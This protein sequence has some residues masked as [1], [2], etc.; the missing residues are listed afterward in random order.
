MPPDDT[1]GLVPVTEVTVP[2]G[3]DEFIVWF[4]QVPVMVTL[5]PATKAGV[6]VPVPPLSTGS[7]VPE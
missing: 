1:T 4:G 7:A 3:L 2:P 6:V 5:V